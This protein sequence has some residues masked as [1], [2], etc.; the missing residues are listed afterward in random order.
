MKYNIMLFLTIMGA[1][2]IG[3]GV[4]MRNGIIILCGI[5]ITYLGGSFIYKSGKEDIKRINLLL[6]A[7]KNN[8]FSFRFR[9][10]GNRK[11]D[12]LV[13]NTLNGILDLLKQEKL[14][15]NQK[16]RYYELILNRLK[17]AIIVVNEQSE[18]IQY[19]S[20]ALALFGLPVLSHLNQ[21]NAVDANIVRILDETQS[22][23]KQHI[24]IMINNREI[25]LFIRLSK[26]ELHGSELK[27]FTINDINN[28]I[29]RK[30]LD[31]W[32][33][34]TRVLTHEIMNGIAPIASIS[35]ELMNNTPDN[36]SLKLINSTSHNMLNFVESY[37]KFTSIPTP[38]PA[39]I[40]VKD[41][42][43]Q[44]LTLVAPLLSEICTTVKI[45]PDDL[46]IYADRA[47]I[48]QVL[49]NIIKNGAEA[50]APEIQNKSILIS[51]YCKEDESV[52]IEISNNGNNIDK[53]AAE[54][55][56][57]PFF[58]TKKGGTGIGLSISRQIMVQ[59]DGMLTLISNYI[60]GYTTTFILTFH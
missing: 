45:N 56:F 23:Q 59:S 58:T 55:I 7:V 28:E 33:K 46:I 24:T 60:H 8:D 44:T 26:L 15:I 25:H 48:T 35:E 20:E 19:N 27:I 5:L 54:Q 32:I 14:N 51:A 40:Y 1:I 38:R 49:F 13:F 16:E 11:K 6:E 4:A 39:L 30:E 10:S 31:S 18:I 41:I 34:L 37:R 36:E 57:I 29:D 22:G 21:L 9:N 52:V 17:T 50:F 12:K 53:E 47:L 2:I 43:S 42:I 3:A